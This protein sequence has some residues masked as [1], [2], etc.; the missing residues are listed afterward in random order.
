MSDN[1]I[2]RIRC[3]EWLDKQDAK[4]RK[5]AE[6]VAIE[7]QIKATKKLIEKKQKEF[8]NVNQIIFGLERANDTELKGKFLEDFNLIALV[9]GLEILEL[10]MELAA[11]ERKLK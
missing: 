5:I 7:N 8:D 3:Q 1:D 9:N 4:A 11:L 6:R 10:S 2:V